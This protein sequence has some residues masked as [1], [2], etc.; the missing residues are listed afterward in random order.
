MKDL[1]ILILSIATIILFYLYS[2]HTTE[3]K[4]TIQRDTTKVVEYD[5]LVVK[6]TINTTTEI[7][8]P[9]DTVYINNNPYRLYT[10]SFSKKGVS[11]TIYSTIDGDLIE[12]EVSVN[13]SSSI[14]IT[15][16]FKNIRETIKT[17]P[18][19]YSI[20]LQLG[21]NTQELGILS[22]TVSYTWSN[23][24]TISLGYNIPSKYP[25]IGFSYSL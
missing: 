12:Q 22:P 14:P 6:D 23:Q 2:S 18:S 9:P 4:T 20:G 17:Y 3:Y 15:R 8:Q 16:T 21:G 11:G 5:T 7:V 1:I 10:T 19:Y 24:N 13:Y 25:I